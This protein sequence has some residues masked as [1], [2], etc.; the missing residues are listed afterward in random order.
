[1][2][3]FISYTDKKNCQ[4]ST[5]T[6]LY[7]K[8]LHQKYQVLS[9]FSR[10]NLHL[11]APDKNHESTITPPTI[12]EHCCCNLTRVLPPEERDASRKVESTAFRGH[13]ITLCMSEKKS[14]THPNSFASCFIA[15]ECI[16]HVKNPRV[17]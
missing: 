13:V 14:Y 9:T 7:T 17:Y 8:Q 4:I 15:N 6:F 11:A 5:Y 3:N 10:R 2:Y 1:M 12:L 16:F